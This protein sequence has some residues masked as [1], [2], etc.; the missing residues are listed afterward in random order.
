MKS[1]PLT[2]T[3]LTLLLAATVPCWAAPTRN[4]ARAEAPLTPAKHD[5]PAD[6]E[7]LA[8]H[9]YPDMSGQ[10]RWF[11]GQEIAYLNRDRGE[12][13]TW[14]VPVY[15]PAKGFVRAD[16]RNWLTAV[17]KG[18]KYR[19][20]PALMVAVRTQENPSPARDH[21]AYGVVS[22]KG[23]NLWTQSEHGARILRRCLGKSAE[24][25]SPASLYRG[26]LVYVGQGEASARSWA[27]AVWTFYRR[28][29]A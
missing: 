8:Q 25:P 6:A 24:N 27:Q 2:T 1:T 28:A 13:D 5:L 3:L 29:T 26:A 16:C 21:Y 18:K 17:C 7:A 9:L 22:Q 14:V 11:V 23:T 15:R 19:V 12:G 20:N 10:E 4:Y